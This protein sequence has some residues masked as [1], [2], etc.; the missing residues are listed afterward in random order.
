[1]TGCRV[2]WI[3]RIASA[4]AIKWT[5]TEVAPL[6]REAWSSVGG[7]PMDEAL[8]VLSCFPVR[9]GGAGQF[10]R[11]ASFEAAGNPSRTTLD[12]GAGDATPAQ[13]G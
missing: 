10:W 11:T 3:L 6:I 13:H 8:C 4:G 1:M 12:D 7:G 9:L 2:Q 5:A